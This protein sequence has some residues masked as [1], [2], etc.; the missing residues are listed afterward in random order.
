MLESITGNPWIFYPLILFGS[1]TLFL[2]I[3]LALKLHFMPVEMKRAAYTHRAAMALRK[4]GRSKR[5]LN[6][7]IEVK[8]ASHGAVGTHMIKLLW[9]ASN[10]ASD[11]EGHLSVVIKKSGSINYSVKIIQNLES[12]RHMARDTH[13]NCRR[14]V[15]TQPSNFY[16]PLNETDF[17]SLIRDSVIPLHQAKGIVKA[18]K[19]DTIKGEAQLRNTV[20][21]TIWVSGG[22]MRNPFEPKNAIEDAQSL[23]VIELNST[24]RDLHNMEQCLDLIEQTLSDF[25]IEENRVYTNASMISGTLDAIDHALGDAEL[26]LPPGLTSGETPVEDP[27]TE[28]NGAIQKIYSNL[29]KIEAY[30]FWGHN[31]LSQ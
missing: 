1:F 27:D 8:N 29:T 5:I 10:D 14:E 28:N 23:S 26:P 11:A 2:I 15:K 17:I 31:S 3:S 24:K 30:L 16:K 21:K 6:R 22:T 25:S 19:E 4:L 9:N 13:E 18:W 7:F 12:Y 20:N